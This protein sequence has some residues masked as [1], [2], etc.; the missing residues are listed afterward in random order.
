MKIQIS[1]GIL[2]GLLGAAR[3]QA[4]TPPAGATAPSSSATFAPTAPAAPVPTSQGAPAASQSP[5]KPTPSTNIWDEHEP[6]E[7]SAPAEPQ[8]TPHSGYVADTSTPPRATEDEESAPEH[9]PK[10][11]DHRHDGFYLRLAL[12]PGYLSTKTQNGSSI[13]GWAVGADVWLGGSP[14]PGLAVAVTF[15]GV[16]APHPHAELS[17]TDTGG[18]GVVSGT[19]QGNLTY[20]VLGLV[21]DYYPDPAGGLHFMAG[22]SYSA[23]RFTAD[24][25]AQSEPASGFGLV[26]GVGYEWWIGREW[27][28][29]PVARLHWASVSDPVEAWSVL[30]PVL[31]LGFTYH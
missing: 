11:G 13:K 6:Q 17:D 23:M 8:Y 5:A 28:V 18:R 14:M 26:G 2:I 21:G 7:P 12:G 25:G 22:M 15:N 19:P 27:S 31:L 9:R 3:A 1:A 29:G 24:N 10:R 16:S 4:Q 30:A 20:S